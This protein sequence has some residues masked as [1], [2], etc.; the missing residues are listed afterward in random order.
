MFL[1]MRETELVRDRAIK[2]AQQTLKLEIL[3]IFRKIQGKIVKIVL[4]IDKICKTNF[5]TIISSHQKTRINM[6]HPQLVGRD[7]INRE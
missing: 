1:H 5:K 4:K 6:F 2:L 3:I 7:L